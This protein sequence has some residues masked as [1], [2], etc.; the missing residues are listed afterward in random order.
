M[1]P[2]ISKRTALVGTG[3]VAVLVL[4]TAAAVALTGKD[5]KPAANPATSTSST[6]K[7]S[8]TPSPSPA[9][10]KPTAKPV[11]AVN[12]LTGVGAPFKGRVLAVKIDD[13]ENGRPPVGLDKA[14]V[15]YIEQAEGGLTRMVA[16]FGTN[17]PL[18]EPVRS[19]RASDA[20]LLSQYGRIQLV[21]S[22][23]GGD[24][25]S[26][27]DRSVVTGVINDRGAAG[28]G[29]DGNRPAPYNLTANLAQIAA[30]AKSGGAKNIGFTWSTPY[31]QLAR[32]KAA[33]TV[34]TV[35][36]STSV[37]FAY[38]PSAHRYARTIGGQKL[39]AA[40]GTPIGAANVLVQLCT[41]RTNPAD[42]DVMGN[43]SQF[44]ETVG[45]G[46]VVLF[47]DGKRVNGTWS[48]T[49]VTGITTYRD[50]RGKPLFMRP[51][52]ATVVLA[53]KGAPVS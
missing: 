4:G 37:T 44:T 2:A 46:P 32:A 18:V 6:P 34:S 47:R 52:G 51:G 5:A 29:R 43:P 42:V 49:S 36:G 13:T 28:F 30:N 23:G 7:A 22:G 26:T 38:V 45:S 24:S 20:E 35:V 48:R 11:A 19:V 39:I 16:V 17:H 33:P 9:P 14:D 21:A 3:V 12:P 40:D 31:S 15:V 10:S 41:V 25:L 27:L 53:T 8:T 1:A 50:L